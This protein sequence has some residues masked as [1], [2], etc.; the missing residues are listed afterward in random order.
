GGRGDALV[1]TIL[2]L[3]RLGLAEGRSVAAQAPANPSHRTQRGLGTS[4]QSRRHLHAGQM[5]ISVVR[6]VGSGVSHD[7]VLPGRSLFREGATVAVPARMVY[8]PERSIARL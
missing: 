7:P 8:A 3:R 5:G 2:S 4:V 1:E 6:G